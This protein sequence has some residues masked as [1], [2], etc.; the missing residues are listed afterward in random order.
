MIRVFLKWLGAFVF[1]CISLTAAIIGFVILADWLSLPDGKS[2]EVIV[3]AIIVIIFMAMAGLTYLLFFHRQRVKEQKQNSR[4]EQEA[5]ELMTGQ[6]PAFTRSFAEEGSETLDK[7]KPLLE[8]CVDYTS[9][10][11][12]KMM[13]ETQS[14]F[15]KF[16]REQHKY[17]RATMLFLFIVMAGLVIASLLGQ[18]LFWSSAKL[19]AMVLLCFFLGHIVVVFRVK[20][21]LKNN[22]IAGKMKCF[23]YNAYIVMHHQNE[24]QAQKE[25]HMIA[26]LDIKAAYKIRG[27]FL[28]ESKEGLYYYI[29]YNDV[30]DTDK[31]EDFLIARLPTKYT[32]TL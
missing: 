18:K 3:Q 25:E 21:Q 13:I 19:V 29:P 30:L 4:L 16:R 15:C 2:K 28:L 26:F 32:N 31:I 24:V 22:P 8:V 27:M 10:D 6:K 17:Y 1:L 14:F 5:L 7:E 9:A 11:V 20:A 23:L 12:E